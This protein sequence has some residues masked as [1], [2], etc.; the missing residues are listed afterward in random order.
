MRHH[1]AFAAMLVAAVA[2][3]GAGAQPIGT[4]LTCGNPG[5]AGVLAPG[6]TLFRF[7]L[8]TAQY[9]QAL[10]NDGS[11]AVIYVRAARNTANQNRW[12]IHFQG[13][14]GCMGDQ[15]C[16][17]RWCSF[18]TNFGSAKMST[19]GAPYGVAQA[20][21]FSTRGMNPLRKWNH[22]L[23]HYC[24]SD[25]WTGGGTTRLA[26][27]VDPATGGAATFDLQFNGEKIADATIDTLLQAAGT[28]VYD[29]D[30]AGPKLPIA[31]P[32]LAGATDVV[33][34][35][36]SAGQHGA[37]YHA[38]RIGDMIRAV[39]PGLESYRV[40]LDAGPGP[41]LETK[42]FAGACAAQALVNPAFACATNDHT[43][44]FQ[45]YRDEIARGF[46]GARDDLESSCF[47]QHA[48]TGDD[49]LCADEIHVVL[50]HLQ[51]PFF[52]RK[53]LQDSLTTP[54]YVAMGF[55]TALDYGLETS[56]QMLDFSSGAWLPEE[57]AAY[58]PGY[59]GPQCTTHEGID[60]DRPFF[61]QKS[62]AGLV[63]PRSFQVLRNWLRGV[64]PSQAVVP[65]A[66]PGALGPSMC[67]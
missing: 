13:G 1:V 37:A 54:T 33:L 62:M 60:V 32:S 5:A 26:N 2:A 47:A 27:A 61:R 40:V 66:V 67:P 10:C 24:S 6:T 11:G 42:P 49:W 8:D 58:V 14:G 4:A 51:T 53:D 46:Y 59:F 15:D 3:T 41:S 22:V 64:A 45:E 16:A 30:Q 34:S 36:A 43:G 38:D 18:G 63:R 17:D 23:V 7:D 25:Y 39:A 55:G 50:N 29:P 12:H 9:P 21:I 19:V 48:A 31:L 35:G 20:G 28:V 65:F 52:T 56:A 57:P 44:Y